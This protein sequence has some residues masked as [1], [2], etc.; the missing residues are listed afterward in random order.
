[1]TESTNIV[2]KHSDNCSSDNFIAK[3]FSS[4]IN[5]NQ[6]CDGLKDEVYGVHWRL[7][8]TLTFSRKDFEEEMVDCDLVVI[9]A[10][11][12]DERELEKSYL[13][14]RIADALGI[15]VLI[16]TINKLDIG[17]DELCSSSIKQAQLFEIASAFQLQKEELPSFVI[18][19]S[20]HKELTIN[21]LWKLRA[22]VE[23]VSLQPIIGVDYSDIYY[24]LNKK[25]I[26]QSFWGFGQ[27]NEAVSKAI[28][29]VEN[30]LPYEMFSNAKEIIITLFLGLDFHV[31]EIESL[32]EGIIAMRCFKEGSLIV[33]GAVVEP[34]LNDY[35]GISIIASF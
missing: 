8:N 13:M 6:V 7:P 25:G 35:K 23:I 27:G 14:A 17:K 32:Y 30:K 20:D 24:C 3:A 22:I 29:D 18:S 21:L 11:L 34:E 26:C 2:L 9:V 28:M 15:L 4:G 33:F 1:M 19:G 12:S 16:F 10:D 5:S 31:D